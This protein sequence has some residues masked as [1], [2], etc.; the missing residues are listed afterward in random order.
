VSLLN[1]KTI[2]KKISFQGI[3]LHSGKKVNVTLK[4]ADPDT[5]IIFKESILKIKI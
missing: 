1:Q 4:G 2:D 5:G 3:G